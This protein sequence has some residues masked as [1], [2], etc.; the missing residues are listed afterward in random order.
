MECSSAICGMYGDSLVM[1]VMKTDSRLSKRE[2]VVVRLPGARIDNV[3]ERVDQ[4]MGIG[5]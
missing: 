2:D 5:N 1:N 3:T 4:I